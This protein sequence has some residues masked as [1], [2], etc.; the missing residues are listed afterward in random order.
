MSPKER[1][2]IPVT[3]F[4]TFLSEALPFFGLSPVALRRRNIRRRITQRMESLGIHEFPVYLDLF[5]RSP[6]ER[7]ALLP[8]LTVTISRFFRNRRTFE[9]LA[10]DVL[11]PLAARSHPARAWSAGCASGE[12]PYTLRILWE[13]LP[14]PKPPLFL[15]GTDVDEACLRRAREGAYSESSLREVP[16]RIVNVYF[17]KEGERYRL[18]EDVVRSAELRRH[19]LLHNIFPGTF[20]LVLCRNAAFTYFDP[21]RRIATAQG[22]ASALP[23]GGVLVIGRTENLPPEA[24]AWFSLDRSAEKIYRRL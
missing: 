1:E 18:R 10:R 21:A 3:E 20:D 14:E 2:G 24:A 19:D 13:E 17:H 23:P 12:E 9:V 15:L 8:L 4:E 5:R 6:Q 11:S 7:D 22:L 16:R